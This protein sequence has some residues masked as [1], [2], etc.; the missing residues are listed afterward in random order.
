MISVCN[1][2]R[3]ERQ[4]VGI[5]REKERKREEEQKR[6]RERE[7]KG[8]NDRKEDRE[9]GE[10]FR[11]HLRHSSRLKLTIKTCLPSSFIFSLG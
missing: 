9:A 10:D 7:R 5:E 4:R 1:V 6:E 11:P 3:E 2:C 8:G